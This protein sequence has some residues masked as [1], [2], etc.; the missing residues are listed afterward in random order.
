MREKS[1][2][3]KRTINCNRDKMYLLIPHSTSCSLAFSSTNFSTSA[4]H[5]LHGFHDLSSL[6]SAELKHG[7]PQSGIGSRS[8]MIESAD[9]ELEE[10]SCSKTLDWLWSSRTAGFCFLIG[11]YNILR[12]LSLGV[13]VGGGGCLC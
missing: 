7:S 4:L 11:L 2:S 13:T 5:T 1:N 3:V 12:K 8:M 6:D 9:D 10:V